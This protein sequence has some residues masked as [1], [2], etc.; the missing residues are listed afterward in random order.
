MKIMLHSAC[1]SRLRSC[2]WTF[3]IQLMRM[4]RAFRFTGCACKGK[5]RKCKRR[6]LEI[7]LNN[8]CI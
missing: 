7:R 4:H 1:N 3:Q 2:M 8:D 6:L 5:C